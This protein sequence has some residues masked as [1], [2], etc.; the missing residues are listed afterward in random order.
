MSKSY[1]N[2]VDPHYILEKFSCEAVRYYLCSVSYYGV[3]MNFFEPA[4]VLMH[5][6]ELKD[7]LGNLIHRGLNLAH[8]Y[9][10]GVVPDCPHD[11]AS[12]LPFDLNK[13]VSDVE[14]AMVNCDVKTAIDKTMEVVRETNK[15]LTAAAPWK[16]KAEEAARYDYNVQKGFELP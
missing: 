15:W 14:T 8:K 16:L 5:N 4:M 1:N 9:C 7:V 11:P 6:S 13:L 2:S 3:D 12:G 10:G